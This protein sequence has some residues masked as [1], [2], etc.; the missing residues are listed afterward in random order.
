MKVARLAGAAALVLGLAACANNGG[1]AS[2]GS[3]PQS[4]G[5]IKIGVIVPLSGPAGPN[6]KDVLDAITVQAEIINKAG[7]VLGRQLEIVSKDDQS[8]PAAG[9]SAATD[10]ASQ[11]VSVVMG[12]WNSPVTLAIQ[13]VLV[14]QGILNITTIPQNASIL[15]GADPDAIRMNAGN[16]VG[17]YTAGQFLTKTL[18]AKKVAFLLESDA[19]G[20][21]AGSFLEKQLTPQGVQVVAQQ[22]FA[23]TDTD[24]RVPLSNVRNSGADAVFSA[25]AAESSGMPALAKQYAEAGGTVPHFA[26]LGTVSP[27]VVQ[28]AGGKAVDGL[29][30]AD[31]YFPEAPAFKDLPGNQAFLT[32]YQARHNGDLPDKYRAL[33]AQSVDVWA[34]AVTKANSLDRQKVADAIHGQTF[35]G[36]V[37]GDVRFTARGQMETK[38]YGFTVKNGEI[39]VLDEIPVPDKVWQ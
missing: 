3:D 14:R 13:P 17:A 12:G 27:K 39:Q 28:L 18:K 35:T 30:S 19:Y 34:K 22:K 29:Y 8:T 16:A 38:V 32:A 11:G 26:G 1:S 10:L 33:G 31:I 36:T 2:G 37:F 4:S 24:F 21:D 9:V 20:N 5:P 6:G 25:N 7:G 15:G 23:Y